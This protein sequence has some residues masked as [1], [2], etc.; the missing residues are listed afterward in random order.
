[1]TWQFRPISDFPAFAGQWRDLNAAVADTPLLD[2]DF[3]AP[4]I[5][6]FARGHEVLAIHGEPA[7][8][9]AMGLLRRRNRALWQTFQPANAPLGPWLSR[10][11]QPLDQLLRKLATALP[12]PCLAIKLSALDPEH[13][14]RPAQTATLSTGDY[15]ETAYLSVAKEFAEY[16]AARPKKFRQINRRGWKRLSREGVK[17]RLELVT[18]PN[19]TDQAVNDFGLLESRGWK[20]RIG[21]AVHPDNAQGRVYRRILQNFAKRHETRIYRFFYDGRLVASDLC[22]ERNGQLINLKTTYDENERPTSP[23][24][25]MRYQVFKEIF[26]EKDISRIEFYGKALDWHRAYTDQFRTLYHLYAYRWPAGQVLRLKLIADR[27]RRAAGRNH[28]RTR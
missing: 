1:M 4:L 5:E 11:S 25:R 3:I 13:F 21:S 2:P 16:W 27:W 15:M 22:L 10:A 23:A 6:E 24:Q 9:V 26:G 7:A 18:H 19:E 28:R 8:P 14:S 20:G 12:G 17:T